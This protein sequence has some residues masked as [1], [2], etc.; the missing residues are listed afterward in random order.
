[1]TTHVAEAL[2]RLTECYL[3]LG[4]VNEAQTAAAVLGHN[5]PGSS[6]YA[7]S[8]A[9]LEG[10]KLAPDEDRGSWISRMFSAVF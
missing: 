2:H 8:Y 3:A 9:L 10:E 6:W 7:H 4:V 5:F 1:M